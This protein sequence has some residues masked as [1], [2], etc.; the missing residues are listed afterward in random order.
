MK[1]YIMVN[2]DVFCYNIQNTFLSNHC[3]RIH[4]NFPNNSAVNPCQ[5]PKITQMFSSL[6][7]PQNSTFS[8][9]QEVYQHSGLGWP[10]VHCWCN[11]IQSCHLLLNFHLSFLSWSWSFL[12]GYLASVWWGVNG[13]GSL[14]CL[15]LLPC[16]LIMGITALLLWEHP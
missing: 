8:L 10:E 4:R 13:T 6:H 5:G 12:W 14:H 9:V 11:W 3:S 16:A 7:G 2:S 1:S 15:A